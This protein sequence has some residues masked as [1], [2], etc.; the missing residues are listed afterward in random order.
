ML[1]DYPR[2]QTIGAGLSRSTNSTVQ[3]YSSGPRSILIEFLI[4]NSGDLEKVD[5]P[6]LWYTGGAKEPS[7]SPQ[8]CD[9]KEIIKG[10]ECRSCNPAFW[11][12]QTSSS[13]LCLTP[14]YVSYSN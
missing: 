4:A 5:S 7:S 8:S 14:T 6:I 10:S 9:G 12:H 1:A 13:S 3:P 11:L 2:Q